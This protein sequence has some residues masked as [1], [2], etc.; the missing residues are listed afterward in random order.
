MSAVKSFDPRR[1]DDP[2]PYTSAGTPASSNVRIL[3]T[4]KPPET[5]I[6]TASKPSRS[7]ARRTL[8]TSRALTP[9]G[10]KSPS[11]SHSERSTRRSEVS[12]RTPQSFGPRARAASS[13]VRTESFSKS[14]ST[15]TFMSSGAQAANCRAASTV[16]PS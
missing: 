16:S 13:A 14:T 5:T 4:E 9:R 6:L 11:S 12:S 8:R 1:S 10:S 7:S 2:T 15:T 3:S